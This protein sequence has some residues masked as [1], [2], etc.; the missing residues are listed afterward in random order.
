MESTWN[1]LTPL[2][3]RQVL[4]HFGCLA[5]STRAEY[6]K[7]L[8]PGNL[9]PGSYATEMQ[10]H[11]YQRIHT[12]MS[13]GALFL[14]AGIRKPPKCPSAHGHLSHFIFVTLYQNS[15]QQSN[16]PTRAACSVGECHEVWRERNQIQ[17]CTFYSSIYVPFK[18]HRTNL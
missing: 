6:V 18:T 9:T 14:V 10:S 13:A 4:H 15:V 5:T 8:S 16:K 12:K 11:M 1:P 17:K 2:V 7:T 3:G